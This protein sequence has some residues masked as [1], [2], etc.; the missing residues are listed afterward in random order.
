MEYSAIGRYVEVVKTLGNGR[1][2]LDI[3]GDVTLKTQ[4]CAAHLSGNNRQEE[5]PHSLGLQCSVTCAE[6]QVRN[7]VVAVEDVCSK[8]HISNSQKR[9]WVI[10]PAA[11]L[12]IFRIDAISDHE[13]PGPDTELMHPCA[14]AEVDMLE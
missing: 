2:S 9:L 10:F 5:T 14:S 8:Q 11:A 1:H 4:S 7:V 3:S 12:K 6:V 13:P